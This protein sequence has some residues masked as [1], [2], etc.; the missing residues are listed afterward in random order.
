MGSG[1]GSRANVEGNAAP[2]TTDE[3]ALLNEAMREADQRLAASLQKDE[4][5]RRRRRRWRIGGIAMTITIAAVVG[6]LLVV[7]PDISVDD[8]EK[9]AGLSQTGWQLWQQGKYVEAE[10]KFAEAVKLDPEAANAWNGLGWS[11]FNG[12]LARE[13]AL[14]AFRQCV[15]LEKNHAAALNGLGQVHLA[16]REYDKAR[17][18]LLKAAS[19][20]ASAAWY[21]LTRIY[22]LEGKFA[23]AAKWA[24]KVVK[25]QPKDALAKKMLAAA[26][27]KQLDDDLPRQIEPAPPA[28]QPARKSKDAQRG[29]SLFSRGMYRPAKLAFQKALKADP[30]D[31]SAHNGLGFLLVNSGKAAEAKKH[32]EQCLE[33]QSDHAGAMNGLAR[34]LKD[35][36]KVDEAVAQW[37]K[38]VE[39][40]PGPHAGV[41]GLA[42]TYLEQKKYDLAIKYYEQIVEANPNDKSARDAL[43]R[44]RKGLR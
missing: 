19:K 39:K 16:Q 42:S 35:L 21:G 29:W 31:A 26:K 25:D 17:K 1:D 13:D 3:E 33:L 37:K 4:L 28:S 14:K 41:Y 27:A 43:E 7:A 2:V 8:A 34:C 6:T 22:L 38:M 5:R 9:A 10:K 15:K 32:F 20:G 40:F 18:Y 12:G 44:A 36:G 24:Q 11:R 30:N 23:A